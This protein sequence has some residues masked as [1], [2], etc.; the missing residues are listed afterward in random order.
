MKLQQGSSRVT[1]AVC[2]LVGASGD[3]AKHPATDIPYVRPAQ[4]DARREVHV[5]VGP[6]MWVTEGAA[7]GKLHICHVM[8]GSQ[9]NHY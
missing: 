6:S 7:R 8:D 1:L 5:G 9:I 2:V 3:H 4:Q